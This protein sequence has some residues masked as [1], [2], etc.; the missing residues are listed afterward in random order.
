MVV[1]FFASPEY[2]EFVFAEQRYEKLPKVRKKFDLQE[3][4]RWVYFASPHQIFLS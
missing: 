3:K 2:C 1:T 4:F